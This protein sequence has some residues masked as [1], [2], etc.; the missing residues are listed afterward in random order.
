MAGRLKESDPSLLSKEEGTVI[1]PWRDRIR[2]CLAYPSPY[3]TGMSNLGFQT[4]YA[5]FNQYPLFPL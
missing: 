2:I 3:R 4:L 1:T 5:L